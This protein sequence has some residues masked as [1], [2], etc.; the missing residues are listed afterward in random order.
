MAHYY[1]LKFV[2]N[3]NWNDVKHVR[4]DPDFE[5]GH[6]SIFLSLAENCVH[7]LAEKANLD[8]Q[9]CYSWPD[10]SLYKYLR[11]LEPISYGDQSYENLRKTFTGHGEK[12]V[13]ELLYKFSVGLSSLNQV[14][15]N[16]MSQTELVTLSERWK[17]SR[18]AC[19]LLYKQRHQE[20]EKCF[21]NYRLHRKN[22]PDCPKPYGFPCENGLVLCKSAE[23]AAENYVKNLVS[24]VEA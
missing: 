12:Q 17:L 15:G 3:G 11:T 19:H 18:E 5:M 13:E 21:Q 9:H 16:E 22:C 10:G 14:D 24:T 1:G 23:K 4:K 20:R 8:I 7:E 2:Y 6:G